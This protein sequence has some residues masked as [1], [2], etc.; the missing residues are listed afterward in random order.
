MLSMKSL[1]IVEYLKP[2]DSFL[3]LT[4]KQYNTMILD[5]KNADVK[6]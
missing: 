1:T 4:G 5:T 6:H 3:F 2:I